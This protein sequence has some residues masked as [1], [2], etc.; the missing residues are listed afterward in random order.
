MS[1]SQPNTLLDMPF[2]CYLALCCRVALLAIEAVIALTLCM[3]WQYVLLKTANS[4]HIRRFSVFLALPSATI[5]AMAMRQGIVDDDDCA[6]EVDDD[7]MEE[8]IAA[9]AAAAAA[10]RASQ[11]KSVRMD[12]AAPHH[13]T[14]TQAAPRP[15]IHL[16]LSVQST[17]T[18]DCAICC[19]DTCH[20]ICCLHTSLASLRASADLTTGVLSF[21][22]ADFRAMSAWYVLQPSP[23]TLLH[24]MH[25]SQPNHRAL[26]CRQNLMQ[27]STLVHHAPNPLLQPQTMP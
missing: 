4:E 7:D 9:E 18:A 16:P 8:A 1:S 21:Q 13:V 19:L 20:C 27:S 2:H 10:G 15:C 17:R 22:H 23:Y 6:E 5:R 26:S 12:A 3:G 24:I 14:P 11:A 25:A